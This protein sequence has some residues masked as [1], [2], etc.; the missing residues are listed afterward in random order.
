MSVGARAEPS[1][2]VT[3]GWITM[4][5]R[6]GQCGG[7]PLLPW[8]LQAEQHTVAGSACQAQH[9]EHKA[10]NEAPLCQADRNPYPQTL[11]RA[12]ELSR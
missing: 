6:P 4:S 7:V 8:Q 10:A 12:Q 3:W 2:P 1:S 9:R 11:C 5:R